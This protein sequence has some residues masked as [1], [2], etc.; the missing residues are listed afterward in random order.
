MQHTIEFEIPDNLKQHEISRIAKEGSTIIIRYKDIPIRFDIDKKW[1]KT[2]EHFEGAAKGLI[3][4]QAMKQAI[5]FFLSECWL[6][7]IDTINESVRFEDTT[8]NDC[9][10]QEQDQSKTDQE[11]QK[12]K[13]TTVAEVLRLHSGRA[14]VTAMITSVSDLYQ[15]V[16]KAGWKCD[17]CGAIWEKQIR[18]ITEPPLKPK[19]CP[20]CQ[21]YSAY[22][23]ELHHYINASTITLQDDL[24]QTSLES[25]PVIVFEEDTEEIHMGENVKVMGRIEKIQDKRS[26]KYHTVLLAESIQYDQRKKLVLTQ[27]DILGNKRFVGKLPVYGDKTCLIGFKDRVIKMF[28]PN[29]IGHEYEKL[30]LLLAV[31]GG[32]ENAIRGRINVLLIGPAGLAKTKLSKEVIKL[33]RGSRYVSAKNTTG[34]SLTAMVLKEEE[35]YTLNLGPVPLAKNAVC[36]INEFDKMKP[37]EQDSLLDVMEEGEITVN[38]FAKLRRIK[39]PTTIIATANPKNNKWQD[40]NRIDLEEI[41]FEATILSRFDIVLTFR[42]I[43]DEKANREF[44]YNKTEYDEKNIL[45]N[46]NFLEKFVEHSKTINPVIT[47]EARSILNEFWVRLKVKGEYVF[48]N[49]TLD[50]LYRISESL[51]R[52]YLND[53]VDINMAYETIDFFNKMLQEFHSYI[54]YIPE[55]KS[56]AY[57]E[58]IKAIQ[59]QKAPIDL[60][61]AVKIACQMNDQVKFYINNSFDQKSNKRLRTLCNK[62]LECNHILRVKLNPI[63]VHWITIEEAQNNST[64]DLSDISD[65]HFGELQMR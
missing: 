42:D 18:K 15:L 28:A 3:Y 13:V 5:I 64:G 63:V 2:I 41:P 24:A 56:A 59:Q 53:T 50:S 62:I 36:V 39:S 40:P 10:S 51:A 4:D 21:G 65:L 58:T 17:S 26:R 30:A 19:Q 12:S 29:V 16:T 32:P 37:E 9:S 31:V 54:H 60:I 52:L 27:N 49:R 61:E 14:T 38:K 1:S 20:S 25:L 57:D 34:G 7:R 45:H 55:P 33:R 43:I 47:K 44:A 6:D 8:N 46:Y 11:S 22:F 48:T 35:S 23:E